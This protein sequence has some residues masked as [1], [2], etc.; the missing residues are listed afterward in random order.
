MRRKPLTS[1]FASR[2]PVDV[3]RLAVEMSWA[4]RVA[5][6]GAH[7]GEQV[8]AGVHGEGGLDVAEPF[9]A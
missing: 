5:G 4:K 2:D 1:E 8:L 7:A 3:Y 6:V 9:W